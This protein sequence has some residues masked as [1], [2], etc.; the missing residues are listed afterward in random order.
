M[1]LAKTR[2]RDEARFAFQYGPTKGLKTNRPYYF[3]DKATRRLVWTFMPEDSRVL[4]EA[5][6]KVWFEGII[7]KFAC[8]MCINAPN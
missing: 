1:E 2:R 6:V 7:E 4:P 8:A 5:D 3:Q